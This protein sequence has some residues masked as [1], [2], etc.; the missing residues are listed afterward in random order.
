M[1]IHGIALFWFT[2]VGISILCVM[3][4]VMN[5]IALVNMMGN[6]IG[7]EF[8]LRCIGIPTVPL[9]IVMGWFV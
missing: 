5:I 9:G 1:E 2:I 3:G 7:G 6:E 8:I 4:W